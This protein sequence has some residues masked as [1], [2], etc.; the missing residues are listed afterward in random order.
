MAAHALRP[1]VIATETQ[2]MARIFGQKRARRTRSAQCCTEA[3]VSESRL[4]VGLGASRRGQGSTQ[5]QPVVAADGAARSP[6]ALDPMPSR[7]QSP[8]SVFSEL[9]G[10]LERPKDA[11]D[12][13]PFAP[14]PRLTSSRSLRS[15]NRGV[16]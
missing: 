12:S 5:V 3:L 15:T 13:Y 7:R 6:P 4:L 11:D 16:P 2:T 10:R 9:V 8:R 14:P 1:Q